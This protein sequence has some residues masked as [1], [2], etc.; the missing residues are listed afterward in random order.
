METQASGNMPRYLILGNLT[1][2]NDRLEMRIA[3]M[4]IDVT[5]TE[6]KIIKE[7]LQRHPSLVQR[8]DLAMLIWGNEDLVM[9]KTINTHLS[10]LRMKLVEWNLKIESIKN[11]GI[12]LKLV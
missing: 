8:K 6:L 10:N 4:K 5:L 9:P 12:L 7:L 11:E 2:D 3:E 1:I